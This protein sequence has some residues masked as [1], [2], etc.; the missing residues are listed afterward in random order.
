MSH[1]LFHRA[2][3][4]TNF[5][6]PVFDLINFNR[7]LGKIVWTKEKKR[8]KKKAK[9]Y[10]RDDQVARRMLEVYVVSKSS[11]WISY[12]MQRA[13]RRRRRATP[14]P[15]HRDK[16]FM[17]RRFIFVRCRWVASGNACWEKQM[18]GVEAAISPAARTKI[19]SIFANVRA[20]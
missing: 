17:S 16:L 19:A 5:P 12:L 14:Q 11:Y 6:P 13:P 2:S 18:I 15:H 4:V 10:D 7:L 20:E 3:D 9:T 8:E 1:I